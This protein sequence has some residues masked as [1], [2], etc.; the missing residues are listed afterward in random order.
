MDGSVNNPSGSTSRARAGRLGGAGDVS[1]GLIGFGRIAQAIHAPLLQRIPGARLRAIADPDPA[2][3]G[4]ADKRAPGATVFEHYGDLLQS[5]VDAVVVCAPTQAHAACALA[6][7]NAGKHVYLEKPLADSIEDG[8]RIVAA[9]ERAG[10]VGMIGFNYRFS[11]VFA[12][13]RLALQRKRAGTIAFAR[14]TFCTPRRNGPGW[15]RGRAGGVLL[16]LA[17]HHIDLLCW[18]LDAKVSAVSAVAASRFTEHD[19]ALVQLRMSNGVLASATFTSAGVDEDVIE[20]IGE[21]G[22]LRADRYSGRLAAAAVGAGFVSE[23]AGAPARLIARAGRWLSR[24]SEPSYA[25]ALSHFVASIR[26][27]SAVTPSLEDGQR[28]LRVVL[29]AEQ[30]AALGRVVEVGDE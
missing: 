12:D 15:R 30:S 28:S 25:T 1:I 7:L 21:A 14:S 16:D 27:G 5:D 23:L 2:A 9:R 3:R 11:P 26:S 24:G 20:V 8:R 4:E 19:T 18:L 22:R 17:S 13:L 6:A 10:V 29:A